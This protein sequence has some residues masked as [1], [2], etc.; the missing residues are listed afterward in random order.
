M[1]PAETASGYRHPLY[2]RSL[3]CYGVPRELPLSGGWLIERA[4]PKTCFH[5]AM[6]PY[7]LFACRDWR[8]LERDLAALEGLVAATLVAD[9]FGAHDPGLLRA[10]FPD[11]MQ[12]YKQHFVTDLARD[13]EEFIASHHRR[14]A[15]KALALLTVEHCDQPA[16]HAGAWLRLYRCLVERHGIAGLA[17]FPDES[18]RLQL[19]VPGLEM[20]RAA[21]G[22]ET[23]GIV[24]WMVSGGVAYYHLGAYSDAGYRL[25][26]SF[27]I[28]RTAID[29]FATRG[30]RWLNLGGG[31]GVGGEGGLVRF[32]RGWSTGVRTA[33]FCGRVLD[34]D[35]FRSL[36]GDFPAAGFFPPYRSEEIC[37][38]E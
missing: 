30:L 24:L 6:G 37:G 26:A 11:V 18:L 16:L 1:T 10:C 8:M 19:E 14:N 34:R 3:A 21:H 35:A 32:K 38:S 12:P 33:W 29:R 15:R 2:A 36:A 17:D 4:I 5:D 23:V 13:P 27:A 22:G 20:L 31:P 9:P 28:F 25:G 7:P